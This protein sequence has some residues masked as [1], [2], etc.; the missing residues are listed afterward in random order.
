MISSRGV[1]GSITSMY[2]SS[3]VLCELSCC[4][5]FFLLI[6]I[7][8]LIGCDKQTFSCVFNT[9]HMVHSPQNI[10]FVFCFVCHPVK[11]HLCAVHSVDAF[12]TASLNPID[13]NILCKFNI[14]IFIYFQLLFL[15]YSC[16]VNRTML[17]SENVNEKFFFSLVVASFSFCAMKAVPNTILQ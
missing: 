8:W 5:C 15:L 12:A 13:L 16:K 9:I 4:V 14:F 3:Y 11:S 1:G 10:R 2:S 7:I 6:S 17:F